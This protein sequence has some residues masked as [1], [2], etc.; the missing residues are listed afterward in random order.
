M[1]HEL[2]KCVDCGIEVSGH[3]DVCPYC[4]G[5]LENGNHTTG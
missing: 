3:V 4:G 1:A 5:V 2:L